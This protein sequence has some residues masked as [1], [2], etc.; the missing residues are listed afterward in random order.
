VRKG[1]DIFWSTIGVVLIWKRG[2]SL[3][4]LSEETTTIYHASA[5]N[6]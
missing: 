6:E 4:N 2:L 5:V 1:R 3:R